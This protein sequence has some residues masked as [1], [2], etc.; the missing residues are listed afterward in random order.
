MIFKKT[1]FN[2]PSGVEPLNLNDI[3]TND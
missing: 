3:K 1:K 2:L